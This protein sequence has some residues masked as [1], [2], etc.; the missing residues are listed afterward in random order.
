MKPQGQDVVA[1]MD[2]WWRVTADTQW[3][4][5]GA[6]SALVGVPQACRAKPKVK[7]VIIEQQLQANTWSHPCAADCVG[8]YQGLCKLSV[9]GPVTGDHQLY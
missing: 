2:A 8:V 7:A 1:P 5:F 3:V 6:R 4:S 9:T